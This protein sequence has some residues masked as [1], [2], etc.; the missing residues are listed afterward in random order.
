MLYNILICDDHSIVRSGVKALIKD[1]LP[2]QRI[3]EAGDDTQLAQLVRS[4]TY[5]LIMLDINIPGVDFMHQMDWLKIMVPTTKVLIFTTHPEEI[6]GR[7]SLQL[8]AKGY[9]N[10]AATN[11]EIIHAVTKVL[12]GVTYISNNLRA[13]L[14]LDP[15]DEKD[16]NPFDK[17]SVREL[18]IAILINEGQSLPKICSTLNIQY[19]TAN[20]HKRR[21]FEKLNVNSTL[22][23]SRLMATFKVVD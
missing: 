19:S 10:K 15:D 14:S 1:H 22:A 2:V 13:I 16:K 20:T 23:L 18:E 4:F 12:Q 17:L 5:D 21:I 9:L 3:D 6:Y 8:G 11:I 7:R